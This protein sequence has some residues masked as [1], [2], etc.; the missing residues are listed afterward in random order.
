MDLPEGW[1]VWNEEPEGR[2]VLAFRPDV[3]D[4]KTFPAE[5]LPVVYVTRGPTERRRP[6]TDPGSR[7]AGDW[8]WRVTLFLEPDVS[9]PERSFTE[10]KAAVD[11]AFDLAAAFAD[12]DVDY[13]DLYQIPRE[14]YFEA[15][16]DLTGRSVRES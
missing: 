10:R 4:S 15:L 13:R 14:D 8:G 7:R 6:P 1:V 9:A 2:L 12:G 3:F 5:C 16:D 11:G